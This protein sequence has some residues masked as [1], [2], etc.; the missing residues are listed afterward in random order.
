MNINNQTPPASP[1]E[2]KPAR[3]IVCPHCKAAWVAEE[4]RDNECFTCGFPEPWDTEID[5][6]TMD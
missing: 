6:E 1:A 4:I 5:D 3:P 2:S